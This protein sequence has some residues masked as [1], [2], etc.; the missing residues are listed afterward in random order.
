[1]FTSAKHPAY[2]NNFCTRCI[3]KKSRGKKKRKEESQA[4]CVH[5]GKM[6]ISAEAR[7]TF[8]LRGSMNG[9]K[10]E[11]EH[12]QTVYNVCEWSVC[13]IMCGFARPRPCQSSEPF[14]QLHAWAELMMWAPAHTAG[15]AHSHCESLSFYACKLIL[16]FV[17]DQISCL[18]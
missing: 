12:N 16:F 7:A 11:R 13:V 17:H 4:N 5:D 2:R 8:A 15:I 18:Y 6:A 14:V 9:V 3:R 10:L 1:M